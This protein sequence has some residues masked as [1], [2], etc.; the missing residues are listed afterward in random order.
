M[1][2]D[3][4]GTISRPTIERRRITPVIPIALRVEVDHFCYSSES[5]FQNVPANGLYNGPHPIEEAGVVELAEGPG[6]DPN[7][8]AIIV[9][10]VVKIF[11]VEIVFDE[12]GAPAV[13]IVRV[14]KH[15]LCEHFSQHAFGILVREL[16]G[17]DRRVVR[18]LSAVVVDRYDAPVIG[19]EA[20]PREIFFSAV[21]VSGSHVTRPISK[22]QRPES[23]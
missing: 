21:S 13:Q 8:R 15:H 4:N 5:S 12:F 7:R 19:I 22:G 14:E 6:V 16:D 3:R 20:I 9:Y 23:G 17:F 10:P 11:N 18:E 2:P 1:V